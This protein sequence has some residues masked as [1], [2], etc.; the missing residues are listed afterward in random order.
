MLIEPWNV[1]MLGGLRV[2]RRDRAIE[3]LRT[4]HV[5]SLFAYLAYHAGRSST[6]DELGEMLWP[7]AH[8]DQQRQNL[9]QAVY[10]LRRHLDSGSGA[11][12]ILS[13]SG[14]VRLRS[15]SVLTDVG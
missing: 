11:S 12:V 4:R 8:P 13:D 6:R 15:E 3:R 1:E 5:A 10:F 2:R 7:D 9:R 14:S